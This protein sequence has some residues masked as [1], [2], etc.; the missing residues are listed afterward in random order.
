MGILWQSNMIIFVLALISVPVSNSIPFIVLHGELLFLIHFGSVFIC[1]FQFNL[2]FFFLHDK[3]DFVHRD[4]FFLSGFSSF[5]L[6]L[7]NLISYLAVCR[8]I[9]GS[10]SSFFEL[11]IDLESIFRALLR[12]WLCSWIQYINW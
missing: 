6:F 5:F 7:L 9:V 3:S 12:L 2:F 1:P 8:V 4:W 10:F 11:V